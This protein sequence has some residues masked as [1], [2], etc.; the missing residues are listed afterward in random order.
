MT[1][2]PK[3]VTGKG[4]YILL[5]VLLNGIIIKQAFI[6]DAAWY[7]LLFIS[8]PLMVILMMDNKVSR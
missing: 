2:N 5:S 6:H 3:K 4:V 7:Q 8:L 1:E